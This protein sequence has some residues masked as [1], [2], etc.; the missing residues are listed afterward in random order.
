MPPKGLGDSNKKYETVSNRKECSEAFN[1]RYVQTFPSPLKALRC[2]Q[3]P[4]M[5]GA[6]QLLKGIEP[7]AAYP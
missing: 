4:L 5:A 2:P 7:R 1:D 6:W 3:S